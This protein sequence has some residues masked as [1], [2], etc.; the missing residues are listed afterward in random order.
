MGIKPPRPQS[1]SAK[2]ARTQEKTRGERVSQNSRTSKRAGKKASFSKNVSFSQKQG[3]NP[4]GSREKT[5]TS[6]A[7]SFRQGARGGER[8][9]IEGRRACFEALDLNIGILRA[10][11]QQDLQTPDMLDLAGRCERA[12]IEVVRVSKSELDRISSH[13]AHQGIMLETKP[14]T[15]TEFSDLMQM[16]SMER[17][18]TPQLI[19]ML[20][21]VVDEG[22]LGAIVRSCEVVGARA[23]IVANARAAQVGVGA[24]KTSAGAVLRVPIVRVANL[25]RAL[26]E[27]KNQ[28]FWSIASTE[29]A[30][31]VL[32]DAPFE[33]RVCLVMGSEEKGI[34][35]L[36]RK[37]CDFECKLPQFGRIESLNV[38]QAA[39]VMCYEWL[40]RNYV[41]L[42]E[43]SR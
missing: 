5:S 1:Q 14:F 33:G 42:Q 30:Q 43:I 22:N 11:I 7:R 38:A 19:V 36:I 32:W 28:G 13:G 15:Y 24:Y 6:P 31:E 26:E 2:R 3:F 10:R 40:K 39:C 12:G 37:S 21:H 16:L 41:R 29:H 25:A 23:V 8:H 35:T 27:L 17:G 4:R 20:D 34:S 9:Y 18:D